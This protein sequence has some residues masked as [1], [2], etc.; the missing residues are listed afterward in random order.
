MLMMIIQKE[1]LTNLL[2]FRFAVSLALCMVLIP[3]SAYVLKDDYKQDL[4][5]Y[6]GRVALYEEH[7]RQVSS[8][9]N[10]GPLYDK[11]PAVL[12]VLRPHIELAEPEGDRGDP[13]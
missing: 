13:R 11:A 12:S 9:N 6:N 1:I 5:D 8:I 7:L 10:I 3:M 2:S 4:R